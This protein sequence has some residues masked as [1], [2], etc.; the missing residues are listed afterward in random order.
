MLEL[1]LKGF[2]SGIAAVGFAILFNVPKRTLFPIGAL[3]AIGGLVKFGLMYFGVGIVFSSFVGA[4]VVGIISIQMAHLKNSPPLVFSIPGVIPMVPGAFAYRMMLG[5]IA[6]IQLEDSDTYIQTLID[7]VNNGAKMSFILM[8][9]AIG[10]SMP[11][12]I[13]RKESIKRSKFNKEKKVT[14]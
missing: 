12:L 4:T 13:T 11:M 7:M 10:V 8:S 3:G 2:W 9:L 1:L 14:V 6:L 5:L